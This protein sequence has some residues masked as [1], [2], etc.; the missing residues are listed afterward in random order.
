MRRLLVVLL[1]SFETLT[2]TLLAAIPTGYWT[3]GSASGGPQTRSDMRVTF[4]VWASRGNC[5][6]AA[7][8]GVVDLESV[9]DGVMHDGAWKSHVRETLA[10][11]TSFYFYL[12]RAVTWL[13]YLFVGFLLRL[14]F[15]QA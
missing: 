3:A 4:E 8:S 12:I 14:K 13:G 7:S 10:D 5:L 6:G 11:V 1:V 9:R 2:L 15:G